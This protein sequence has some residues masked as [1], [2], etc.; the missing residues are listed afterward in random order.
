M[1]SCHHIY[2]AEAGRVLIPGCMGTAVY[3][4]SGCTC[5]RRSAGEKRRDMEARLDLIE[6]NLSSI[7]A[8]LNK[9]NTILHS[10]PDPIGSA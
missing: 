5:P 10:R 7:E 1:S 2:D 8:T 4:L 9:I 6:A 3:G